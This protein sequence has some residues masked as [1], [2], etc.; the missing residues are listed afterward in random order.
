MTADKRT[1]RLYAEALLKVAKRLG[2]T[3]FI[4][5]QASL[6]VDFMNKNPKLKAF[7]EVPHINLTEKKQV[8][9]RL[10]QNYFEPELLN[11]ILILIDRGRAGD[12][13]LILQEFFDIEEKDRGIFPAEVWTAFSLTD[14]QKNLLT[15]ALQDYTGFKLRLSFMV[16]S[17]LIGGVIFRFQ[18]TLIDGSLW[19]QLMKIKSVM[20]KTA[21]S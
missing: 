3:Q 5:Q 18:D 4:L 20:E 9:I 16:D 6:L 15:T 12:L 1:L 19:G 7:L 13:P 8:M 14:E 10:L 17:R 21:L 2:K 11:L